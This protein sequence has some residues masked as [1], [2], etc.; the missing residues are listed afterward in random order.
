MLAARKYYYGVPPPAAVEP[1]LGPLLGSFL[2]GQ[3]QRTVGMYG[4]G[5]GYVRRGREG[6]KSQVIS[7]PWIVGVVSVYACPPGIG[8]YLLSKHA[9]FPILSLLYKRKSWV[10]FC[11]RRCHV[12]RETRCMKDKD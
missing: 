7:S 8:E 3:C 9:F 5:D 2:H 10:A 6:A 4:T 1:F 12:R 11:R